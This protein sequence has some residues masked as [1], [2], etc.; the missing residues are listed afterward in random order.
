MKITAGQHAFITGGAS[1]LG[2]GIADAFIDRGV[3]VTIADIDAPSLHDVL[4]GRKG[5]CSGVA[6][7]TRNRDNWREARANAEALHGPVDILVNNAGIGPD[8]REFADMNPDSF[9]RIIAIN[10]TGIFNGISTFAADMRRRKAGHI[11]N[12]SSIAGLSPCIPG[13]G[14]YTVAKFGVVAMSEGLRTE[15]EPHGVGV[16]VLCPGLVATNLPQSTLKLGGELRDI[17]GSMGDSGISTADVGRA[18]VEGIEANHLYI[19]THPGMWP[20]V[21]ARMKTIESAF[22][23]FDGYPGR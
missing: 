22:R 21:E 8:G 12:T 23:E 3:A 14:A 5:N 2:L 16:S 9:D 18:V 4:R 13:V 15:M 7:D 1:G 10:L 17:R 19:L 11:V 20:G 6:L